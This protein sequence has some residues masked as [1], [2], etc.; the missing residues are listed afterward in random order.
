MTGERQGRDLDNLSI[1]IVHENYVG[2]GGGERVAEALARAFDA[3]IYY[4]VGDEEHEPDDVECH[5]LFNDSLLA[6][7]LRRSFSLRDAYY[8]LAFRSVPE[9]LEYDVLLQSGNGTG[10]YKPTEDQAVVKYTHS[11]PRNA[12]DRYPYRAPE[13]GLVFELYVLATEQLYQPVLAYPDLYVAN[14]EVVERRLSKYWDRAGD[15]VVVVYPPVDVSGLGPEHATD[16]PDGEYYL[17]LDRLVPNKNVDEVVAAFEE[18]D[19]KR[20]VVAG[21]GPERAA[22][23]RRASDLPNVEFLGY[24]DEERKRA[25]LAGAEALVY[26]ARDEDFGIVPVEALAS[27]TPVV[28]PREGFTRF[29]VDDGRTGLLYDRDD[30]GVAGALDRFENEGVRSTTDERVAAA[31]EY[32]VG[33]F[34]AEMRDAV[35]TAIEKVRIDLA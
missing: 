15:D 30:G 32:G 31:S 13:R 6:P 19:D 10:W 17:V 18:H 23:E 20:L 14:S 22:L 28:G 2:R 29:Q 3:P 7:V 34:E 27:G 9:L 11:T 8:A 12:Y 21:S 16:A 35:A 33:R 24:V 25:L 26:A 4:G 1:A 5:S